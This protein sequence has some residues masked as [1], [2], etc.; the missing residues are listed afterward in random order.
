MASKKLK[1]V[2]A[3]RAEARGVEDV[4]MPVPLNSAEREI[5]DSYSKRSRMVYIVLAASPL[6]CIGMHLLY[7]RG[8]WIMAGCLGFIASPL[9]LM[10]L[11]MAA[12][13]LAFL[14]GWVE[15]DF[16]ELAARDGSFRSVQD[17][18]GAFIGV[19]ICVVVFVGVLWLLGI[20]AAVRWA[21]F[22]DEAAWKRR[23]AKGATAAIAASRESERKKAE[24]NARRARAEAERTELY[25]GD[26]DFLALVRQGKV[27]IGMTKRAV[28]DALGVPRDT[29]EDIS[30]SSRKERLYYREKVGARGK[31]T[32]ELEI[33]LVD[34]RVVK[35]KDL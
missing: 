5:V 31:V 21:F 27:A 14:L 28:K 6:S 30:A 11:A 29:K 24:A 4:H 16:G 3:E 13:S 10:M 33:T 9:L 12:Q 32:Y 26:P 18:R 22:R 15:F 7:A 17:M 1:A 23:Q 2:A 8:G 19:S 25:G 34:D 20:C 35:I